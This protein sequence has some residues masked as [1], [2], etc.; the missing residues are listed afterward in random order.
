M[1]PEL[2]HISCPPAPWRLR[3]SSVQAL[4]L[5]RIEH[6]RRFVPADVRV[7]A[8]AP[9]RTL[10]VMYCARYETG[11]TLLYSELAMAPAL[12][13]VRGKIGFW[14]SHIYVDNPV[15]VAG[16]REIWHLPKQLA[17]FD[18]HAEGREVAVTQGRV[19]LCRVRWNRSAMHVPTPVAAP[20]LTE[21]PAA[22][23]LFWIAGSCRLT[24]CRATLSADPESPLAQLQFT[25]TR[26]LLAA[27][28]LDLRV[29]A[30][31]T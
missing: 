3:G 13:K 16:G 10:A 25:G 6:V 29:K 1:T 15:S 21:A 22:F 19:E 7:V 18:W 14:I 8:V 30:P 12:V 4:R 27:N 11:S 28:A 23:G 5:V 2:P 31:R 20:V 26:R 9:R 24:Q 17:A